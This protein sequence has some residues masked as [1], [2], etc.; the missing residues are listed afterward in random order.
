MA[1]S[2]LDPGKIAA[3]F[4]ALAQWEAGESNPTLRQLER[5]AAATHTPIGYL[6]LAA[7]PSEPVPLPDY[8]TKNGNRRLDPSPDLLETVYASQRRQEWYREYA[9]IRGHEK[10]SFIGA[11]TLKEAPSSVAAKMRAQLGFRL[12]D[13]LKAKSWEDAL[14]AFIARL[15]E[16]GVLVMVNGVVGTNSQRPLDILEFRGFSMADPWAP[17]IFVNGRDSKAAQMF[18]VAHE[19]AHLWLGGSALDDVHDTGASEAVE[20]W[21]NGVAAEL[22]VPLAE[23]KKEYQAGS[24]LIPEARRLSKAFKVSPLVTLIRMAEA[25]VVTRTAMWAAYYQEAQTYLRPPDSSGGNFYAT[26]TARLGRRFA[27]ALVADTREGN[28]LYRDAF[29][30]S[31]VSKGETFEKWGDKLEVAA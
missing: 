7:P 19:L 9:R 13:Q 21:C 3:K 28:T 27:R 30:L 8:R 10:L 5:F 12:A 16:G 11:G 6:F 25:G 29:R 1:R 24:E 26:Q 14:R 31:G 18:T 4:P 15:D 22:L 23:F 2:R 20:S 17:V